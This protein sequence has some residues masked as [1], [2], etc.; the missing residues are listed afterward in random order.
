MWSFLANARPVFTVP[1]RLPDRGRSQFRVQEV[2]LDVEAS[3]GLVLSGEHGQDPTMLLS[4]QPWCVPVPGLGGR[5]WAACG[6]MWPA[7]GRGLVK[8][9]GCREM[10]SGG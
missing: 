1:S 9:L 2:D 8:A 3:M 5:R 4:R 7:L 10:G 6:W